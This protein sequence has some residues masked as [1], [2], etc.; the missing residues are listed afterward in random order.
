LVDDDM[1]GGRELWEFELDLIGVAG[2][3]VAVGPLESSPPLGEAKEVDL[4][5]S[6]VGIW[7]ELDR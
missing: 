2:A 7:D 5:R 3:G 1:D 4:R 6:A